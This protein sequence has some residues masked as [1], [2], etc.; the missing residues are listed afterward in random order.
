MYCSLDV[1]RNNV[2]VRTPLSEAKAKQE[3]GGTTFSFAKGVRGIDCE[4][5]VSGWRLK[6][7]SGRTGEDLSSKDNVLFTE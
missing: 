1:S 7:P 5:G 3:Q 4:A 2:F 6:T